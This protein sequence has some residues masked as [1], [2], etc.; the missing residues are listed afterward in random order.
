MYID[1]HKSLF[2]RQA[3][4]RGYSEKHLP[5]CSCCLVNSSIMVSFSL[6]SSPLLRALSSSTTVD[7][8]SSTS[9]MKS[10]FSR[11]CSLSAPCVCGNTMWL[12]LIYLV[13]YIAFN[14]QGHIVTGS[15]QMKETTGH[16]Q[17][18]TN[19]SIGSARAEI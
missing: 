17:V 9:R 13:F 10:S 6:S 12:D 1:I 8:C 11:P 15:L 19:F 5:S 4:H 3:H 2:P 16:W 7:L 14:S 18:T